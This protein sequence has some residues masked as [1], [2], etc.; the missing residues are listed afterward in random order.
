MSDRRATD[1]HPPRAA[2]RVLQHPRP[3]EG[4]VAGLQ[5][6]V[7]NAALARVLQRRIRYG[8]EQRNT[9][10]ATLEAIR[11]W[12]AEAHLL[13]APGYDAILTDMIARG[14]WTYA[15]GD[16]RFLVADAEVRAL[17]GGHA[18]GPAEY[19]V[20][21]DY[22]SGDRY[23][24]AAALAADR[25]LNVIILH[26][27]GDTSAAAELQAFYVKS[28]G[29]R[30]AATLRA[31]QSARLTYRTFGDVTP[32]NRGRLR[33]ATYGTTVVGR[34]AG[35][36]DAMQLKDALTTAWR[37]DES[38]A[39]KKDVALREWLKGIGLVPGKAYAFLWVKTGAM[40][41]E[42][43][44]HFTSPAAWNQLIELIPKEAGRTPV[45]V[46]EPLAGVTTVPSLVRF[47]DEAKFPAD[48]KAEGRI[49]QLR[50][51]SLLAASKDYDVVN[52]GMRSGAL[53]G[54]ALVGL[55]T[56]YL[57]EKGNQQSQRMEKWLKTL[58]SYF[59][60]M[61]D[62]PPGGAFLRAW[63][64]ATIGEV[65]SAVYR[66]NRIRDRSAKEELELARLRT[67]LATAPDRFIEMSLHEGLS[68][69]ETASVLSLLK[70][71]SAE[72]RKEHAALIAGED[73]RLGALNPPVVGRGPV[74]ELKG[75]Q[76][77]DGPMAVRQ[78]V[79]LRAW[80]ALDSGAVV[81]T[82]KDVTGFVKRLTKLLNEAAP[83]S[84]NQ[85]WV[86]LL[87]A[88]EEAEAAKLLGPDALANKAAGGALNK[89]G[90]A[91][92]DRIKGRL[93]GGQRKDIYDRVN[94]WF[95][96]GQP[97]A[98]LPLIGGLA[99]LLTP[100]ATTQAQADAKW[101]K[102]GQRLDALA[103]AGVH[104]GKGLPERTRA[105]LE[106]E[107][108]AARREILLYSTMPT[109]AVGASASSAPEVR[110]EKSAKV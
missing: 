8:T 56:I 14:E 89:A 24:I 9:E 100:T 90:W 35:K 32:Q 67:W 17:I 33:S 7:G 66:L 58:P 85:G 50:L 31:V 52:V 16:Q 46:G 81:T 83:D 27:H 88:V 43:S 97:P 107:S 39:A 23:G 62:I 2:P 41:A 57:E 72:M 63:L 19:I 76:K 64:D 54:P 29:R 30:S 61:V 70:L 53:E 91:F 98:A 87:E 48:V 34:L 12:L 5:R 78:Y 102:I 106:R 47:W 10:L 40:S 1:L 60:V 38:A 104:G 4:A 36:D 92:H 69:S 84:P 25:S 95:D 99:N 42:K 11:K 80:L 6:M 45:L 18:S 96:A 71:T 22:M 103:T 75:R 94:R 73:E 37:G 65:R 101:L 20:Q 26:G 55:P 3:R 110:D 44:H 49:G 108:A 74:A 28:A 79:R 77:T 93:K 59:R 86:G 68:S 13:I 21:G 105:V 15:D 82:M 109:G 51:F